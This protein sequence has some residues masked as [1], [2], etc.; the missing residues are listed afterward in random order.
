MPMIH[1]FFVLDTINGIERAVKIQAC[2]LGSPYIPFCH[3]WKSMNYEERLVMTE[4]F[5]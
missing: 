2:V 3:N 4:K 1:A 5:R